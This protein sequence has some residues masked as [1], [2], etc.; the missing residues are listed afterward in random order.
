M[1]YIAIPI[2]QR[3]LHY[4]SSKGM[5]QKSLLETN[6]LD[7][8]ILNDANNKLPLDDY[9]RLYESALD[10]VKDENFGLHLGEQAELGDLYVLGYIM[11]NCENIGEALNRACKYFTLIGTVLKINVIFEERF[12][13][14]T[15]HLSQ[16]QCRPCLKHCVEAAVTSFFN[17]IKKIA[18]STIEIREIWISTGKPEDTGE[19]D[20][21]FNCPIRYSQ[22][23]SAILFDTKDL[24]IPIVHPNAE[25]RQ[26]LE[27][28]ASNFL[29]KINEDNQLSRKVS[30]LLFEQIK[31]RQPTINETAK[32]IGISVRVLQ[33]RLK[34][35]GVT[36]SQLLTN[37]RKELAISY[38]LDGFYTVDDITYLLGFSEPSVF[39][40]AFK[41][42]TGL[43]PGQYRLSNGVML[44]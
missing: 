6:G 16:E 29:D 3:L 36:F 11:A 10:F 34:H 39:R 14:L 22:P 2:V 7:P 26:V 27:R 5:D 19:Y 42:W 32:R 44:L 18:S 4:A 15:F 13:K 35:E 31:G 23:V 38:L 30:L 43:T 33:K 12:S 17:L 21:I 40:R 1:S 24:K 28:H 25:L 9:Y 37:V 41:N 20:R 8:S